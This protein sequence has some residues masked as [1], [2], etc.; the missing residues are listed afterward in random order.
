MAESETG[1]WEGDKGWVGEQP[2]MW[3]RIACGLG[4]AR[5]FEG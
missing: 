4:N 3:F 5:V 1:I 2:L